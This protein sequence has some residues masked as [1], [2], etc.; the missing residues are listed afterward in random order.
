[1]MALC[2]EKGGMASPELGEDE[3]CGAFWGL[4]R[5][6]GKE[7]RPSTHFLWLLP[8]FVFCSCFFLLIFH[9]RHY[10]QFPA[11]FSGLFL[12][13]C[14]LPTIRHV[15]KEGRLA[16]RNSS[17]GFSYFPCYR[18]IRRFLTFSNIL[19]FTGFCM[20]VHISWRLRSRLNT[21]HLAAAVPMITL[22]YGT[23]G[24]LW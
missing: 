16:M 13:T 10:S 1:M 24:T 11:F 21:S 15:R 2:P 12:L 6:N 7:T 3:S 20:A 4:S 18:I 23:Y 9:F 14:S 17:E 22:R 8:T 19:T 5:A